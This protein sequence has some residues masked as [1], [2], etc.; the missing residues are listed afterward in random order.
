MKTRLQFCILCW[1]SLLRD[2]YF[3]SPVLRAPF[4]LSSPPHTYRLKKFNVM[5]CKKE[6]QREYRMHE[7]NKEVKAILPGE[8]SNFEG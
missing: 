3:L 2:T 5:R 4:L 8:D 7:N 6:L 1:S